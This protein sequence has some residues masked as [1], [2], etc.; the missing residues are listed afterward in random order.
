VKHGLI[1]VFAYQETLLIMAVFGIAILAM[2][3]VGFRRWLQSR[4][5]IDRLLSERAA[6]QTAQFSAHVERVEARLKAI[7]QIVSDG[8]TRAAAQIEASPSPAAD[9]ILKP[10]PIRPNP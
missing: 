7:E 5:R 3:W 8:G 4:E 1:E 9:P 6:E 10:D 2:V